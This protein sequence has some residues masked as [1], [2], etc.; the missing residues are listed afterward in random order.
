MKRSASEN[1]SSVKVVLMHASLLLA[2]AAMCARADVGVATVD[3]VPA[4]KDAGGELA[5][6]AFDPFPAGTIVPEGWLRHQ[7]GLQTEGLHGRLYETSEYLRADNGW[8]KPEN[9]GWEEQAYWLRTFVKLAVLTRNER[10]LGV[11]KQWIDGIVAAADDDGWFGPREL[12]NHVRAANDGSICHDIWAHMVMTEALLTWYDY[13]GDVRVPKLLAAFSHWCCRVP[14]REFLLAD[15]KNGSWHYAVQKDRACDIVPS[16]FRLYA[17]TGDRVFLEFADRC[18]RFRSRQGR[19]S[20]EL[21]VHNVNFAQRFSYET[22]YSR[23]SRHPAHRAS[24]DYWFDLNALLWGGEMPRWAY[25]SDECVRKGCYDARYATETCA[26]GELVRSFQLVGAITGDPKWGDRAE[27]VVYNDYPVSFTP[28]WKK[29][30]Y[31]TAPNQVSLDAATDHNYQKP[32]PRLAYSSKLYRCC[33]HNAGLTL[34]LFAEKLTQKTPGGDLVFFAYAPH[35]GRDGDASWSMETK[36]PFRES[37]VL[38]L[39]GAGRRAIYLRVPGWARAFLVRSGAQTIAKADRPGAWL[40][41]TG[42]WSAEEA[43]EISMEAECTFAPHVRSQSVTIERGP[44]S[45]SLAIKELY[46]DVPQP[47]FKPD[48]KGILESH[49]P[50]ASDAPTDELLTEVLPQ[51]PWN[52]ALELGK[53][54][55]FRLR[56][57]SDDCFAAAT[58]PCEIVA[59]GRRVPEW[60]AQDAQPAELQESPVVASGPEERLRFIPMGAARCRLTVLPTVGHADA[61]SYRWLRTPPKTSRASRPGVR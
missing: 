53:S 51:S 16:L 1:R 60:T 9:S 54:P 37:V 41:L 25:A 2:A 23:R 34:P 4:P 32:P 27:D 30:H 38:R 5:P 56:E 13:C 18:F 19:K 44:L 47:N 49:F 39:R 10:M 12:R 59:W 29:V 43:L 6:N 31:L 15:S 28:D 11:S 21:D 17:I 42:G 55:E 22:V 33:R 57:W 46:R 8:L 58:T 40:R 45:Y 52:Y 14:D 20:A 48:E 24:A 3:K 26:W 35:S 36:Y 7:L 61:Q 50:E